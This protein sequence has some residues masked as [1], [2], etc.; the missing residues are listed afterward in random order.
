MLRNSIGQVILLMYTHLILIK[1][2]EVYRFQVVED[3]SDMLPA[4]ISAHLPKKK[5]KIK[6]SLGSSRFLSSSGV[7][8]MLQEKK[9][10]TFLQHHLQIKQINFSSPYMKKKFLTVTT[11]AATGFEFALELRTFQ[12]SS[13]VS[14]ALSLVSPRISVTYIVPFVLPYTFAN[15]FYYEW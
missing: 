14:D 15:R 13:P 5:K 8:E 10:S 2:V 9:E 7:V 12:F 6:H 1:P 4:V 3:L 11:S